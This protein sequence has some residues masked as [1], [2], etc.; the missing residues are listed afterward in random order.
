M[1]HAIGHA[2]ATSGRM[3]WQITWS[4]ILGFF[5]SATVQSL[6]AKSTIARL[7]PDASPRSLARAAAL[8]TASSSCSYAAAALSR[9][10]F[11]KGADFTAATAFLFASTNLVV[12][13]GLI[14]ALLIGW[15]FTA[16]EFVGGPVMI[17]ALAWLFGRFLRPQAVAAARAQADKGIAGSMEGHAAMDMSV[18]ASGSLARRLVSPSGFTAV[19]HNFVME[20]AAILRD[21]VIG[22]L[23]AGAA[24]A[25]IPDGFWHHLFLTDHPTAAKLW[26]PLIGPLVSVATSVCSIGNVPLAAVLWNGG[27][28]FGGVTAFIFADLIIPPLLVIYAKYYG[29][30][31]AG[32]LFVTFYAV[33]VFAGYVVELLFG[34]LG[35]IPA[36]PRH[37]SMGDDSI[38][39]DY[40]SVLNIA[41]LGLAAALVWR[42]LTTGGPRMLAMMGGAPPPNDGPADHS[43]MQ[44]P[45]GDAAPHHH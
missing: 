23:I 3:T 1:I 11:R 15:Q 5:L 14:L 35:G 18:P 6:V 25:W 45:G 7:L 2:L 30:R 21:L 27:I 12:E 19:S 4:L 34:A 40:T 39:W 26:G 41:L 13:L 32:F 8:G 31:M 33:M 29:R 9:S 22:L 44:M 17:V 43:H 16:A 38:R 20:W 42:F 37:A 36:G 10:L 28:S 24:A